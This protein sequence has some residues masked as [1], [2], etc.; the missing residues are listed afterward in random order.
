M[1][2]ITISLPEDIHKKIIDEQDSI[3][4]TTDKNLSV[5]ELIIDCLRECM[6]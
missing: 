6:K 2:Q 5:S 1:I 3:H 4:R